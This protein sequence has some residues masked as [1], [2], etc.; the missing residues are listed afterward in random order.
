MKKKTGLFLSKD[1][2]NLRLLD[3]CEASFQHQFRLTQLL[4]LGSLKPILLD[5]S[6]RA[7]ETKFLYILAMK[8]CLVHQAVVTRACALLYFVC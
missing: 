2:K 8:A 5:R 1:H 4:Q 3:A 7:L 6:L